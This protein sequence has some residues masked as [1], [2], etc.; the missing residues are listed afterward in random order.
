MRQH[1]QELVLAA[2]GVAQPFFAFAQTRGGGFELGG[3]LADAALQL[4]VEALEL[5]RLAVELGEDGDLGAQDLGDDRDRDVVH[6]PALVAAQAIELGEV[7]RRHEQERGLLI[8]RM[9]ADHGRQL[10]AVEVRHADVHQHHRDLVAQELLERLV[11]GAGGDQVLVQ[12]L[13]DGL[14]AEQLAGLVVDQQDRDSLVGAHRSPLR[15]LRSHSASLLNGGATSAARR[16]AA[17]C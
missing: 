8:A 12:L 3:A 15:R 16:A 11:G 7:D 1:G 2:V 4:L 9:L 13:E 5:A 10:E 17:R 6:R 14:I